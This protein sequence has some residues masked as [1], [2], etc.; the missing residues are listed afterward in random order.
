MKFSSYFNQKL[1]KFRPLMEK[2][3]SQTAK[4]EGHLARITAK[5]MEQQHEPVVNWALNFINIKR[6]WKILEIGFGSG[7]NLCKLANFISNG[8]IL[9]V[10]ISDSM[11]QMSL[12]RIKKSNFEKKVVILKTS[13]NFLPFQGDYFDLIIAIASVHYWNTPQICF[14]EIFRIL[15]PMGLFLTINNNFRHPNFRKYHDMLLKHSPSLK[16]YSPEEYY[17]FYKKAGFSKIKIFLKKSKNWIFIRGIK[18]K[19][20]KNEKGTN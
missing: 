10:E 7:Y 8:K 9:G 4:P 17:R 1:E 2:I 14:N 20:R 3:V 19:K 16:I 5:L 18:R 15:K 11:I 13:A 6:N 12:E